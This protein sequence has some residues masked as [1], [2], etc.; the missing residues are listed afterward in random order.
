MPTAWPS[1]LARRLRTTWRDDTAAHVE[2]ARLRRF[3]WK[4]C[5]LRPRHHG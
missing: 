2:Q 5:A 4:V 3:S 1:V